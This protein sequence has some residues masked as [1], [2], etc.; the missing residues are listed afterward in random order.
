[1]RRSKDAASRADC[2]PSGG[3]SKSCA[4]PGGSRI[5]DADSTAVGR[6]R[7]TAW[8]V[9]AVVAIGLVAFAVVLGSG[10]ASMRQLAESQAI[11]QARALAQDHARQVALRITDAMVEGSDPAARTQLAG[12]VEQVV[13]S[14]PGGPVVRVKLWKVEAGTGEIVSSDL[15]DLIGLRAKLDQ[16]QNAVLRTGAVA[17]TVAELDRD[18]EIGERGLGPLTEVYARIRTPSG[19][20]LLFETYQ[21]SQQVLVSAEEI[22][23]DVTPVLVRTVVAAVALELLLAAILIRRRAEL[24]AAAMDA[25]DK[26]RRTIVDTLHNGAVQ[27]MARLCTNLDT[28]ARAT[29]DEHVR[30][31]LQQMAATGRA[32][33]RGLH[34]AIVGLHP[35]NLDRAGLHEALADLLTR[36]PAKIRGHLDYQVPDRLDAKT[37]ELLFRTSQEAIRDIEERAAATNVWISVQCLNDWAFLSVHDD[38]AAGAT[39]NPQP[40]GS[41]RVG[42]AVLAD[43]IR[44]AGGRIHVTPT[45]TS[46]TLTV[47]IPT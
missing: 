28:Q 24:R 30:G 4:S 2:P 7:S 35:L 46:T 14:R 18:E 25:S 6:S 19:T 29:A 13:H 12:M 3:G 20:P 47:Q 1:M 26:E 15:P 5:R 36:L 34:A 32:T 45:G 10:L 11:A 40:T 43:I 31:R 23:A 27:E 42:L 37:S 9:L 22:A 38:G 44:D 17:A 39:D 33:L 21:H 8:L 16:D 41:G